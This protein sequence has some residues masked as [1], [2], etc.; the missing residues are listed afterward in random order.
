M[1]DPK[2]ATAAPPVETA[3]APAAPGRK[4]LFSPAGLIVLVIVLLAEGVIV[5]A[6]TR[7]LSTASTVDS[8]RLKA[9]EVTL[10]LDTYPIRSSSG[11][12][13]GSTE[14]RVKV[15]LRLDPSLTDVDALL[16]QLSGMRPFLDDRVGHLLDQN[17]DRYIAD[18][19]LVTSLKRD[20]KKLLNDELKKD[21]IDEVYIKRS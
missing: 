7:L 17:A 16:T 3:P 4:P 19:D 21:I 14:I 11:T 15:T 2:A 13:L 8:D 9:K 5:Y 18:P 20:I 12:G 6:V 10:E 1:A